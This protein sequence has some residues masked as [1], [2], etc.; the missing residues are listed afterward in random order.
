[1]C[2]CLCTLFNVF[3]ANIRFAYLFAARNSHLCI[4]FFGMLLLFSFVFIRLYFSSLAFLLSLTL[5]SFVEYM[6]RLIVLRSITFNTMCV[7]LQANAEYKQSQK[8]E[9]KYLLFVDAKATRRLLFSMA[10]YDA[11]RITACAFLNTLHVCLC[12]CLWVYVKLA[13]AVVHGAHI[14]CDTFV[15]LLAFWD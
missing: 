4:Q 3:S 5:H 9:G 7:C 8:W 2:M 14:M 6:H 12:V 10:S 1:M 15:G 13:Q 11:H